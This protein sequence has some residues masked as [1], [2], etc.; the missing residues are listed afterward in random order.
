M[1]AGFGPSFNGAGRLLSREVPKNGRYRWA[2][3]RPGEP[4]AF[5]DL[6]LFVPLVT[7]AILVVFLCGRLAD[8][9]SAGRWLEN[10]RILDGSN[11]ALYFDF[12]L[13]K[14]KYREWQTT[15]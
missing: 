7:V 13:A 6:I 3:T 9:T 10:R 4:A 1:S 15:F 2:M 11:P 14:Y 5:L 12:K 8:A